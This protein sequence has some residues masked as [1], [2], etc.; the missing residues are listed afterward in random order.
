V[1]EQVER[2]AGLDVHRDVVVACVRV[3]GG[4]RAQVHKESFSTTTAGVD[5]LARWMADFVVTRVVMESTG[6]YWKPVYY[7]LE[8]LFDEL[9]LVNARHVK[10]VPGRK[11]DMA[12][13]EWLADVAAHGMVRPSFVPP[14]AI[15][16]LREL[17]R[18][19]KT[20]VA[21]RAQEVQRLDKVLQDAG[22]KISSVASKVLGV[23]T[24]A[25]IEALIAGERDPAV[26]AEMAR[27]R[28]RTKI[29]ELTEVLVGRFAAHHA[30]VARA[31]LDH[32][33]FLD[34][35]ITVLD[36]Q[37]AERVNPFRAAVELL[38]TIPGWGQTV[39]EVFIAEAG[40]DMSRFPT[41]RHLAA[42][43]GVAP[44][45]HESAGKRRP[46]GTRSGAAW[47]RRTM[48]EAAK[49]AGRSRTTYLGAQYRHI[50]PRR[51]PN[52]ATV[53]VAHSMVVAAWHMLQTGQ[54]YQDLGA[55]WFTR[56]HDPERETRRLVARLEALGH[57]VSLTSAA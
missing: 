50:A 51:G 32:I 52:K 43:S 47:L 36:E 22:I 48:I 26:L 7:G 3:G 37:I 46:A 31:I 53:A 45:N 40:V 23:S 28:M 33:D 15:R 1:E 20:Q 19:R 55:D 56:R 17:T 30:V 5:R 16:E 11:T 9:W 24:R 8:G 13:A 44:A 10:N 34:A 38:K 6:V 12:D 14:P 4:R 18:Y 39:A 54:T 49:A 2:V 41:A 57:T 35:N 29:P 27:T 42:W 25:M 21:V